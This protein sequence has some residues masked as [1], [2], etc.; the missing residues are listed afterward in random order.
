MI[1]EG[2]AANQ[3]ESSPNLNQAPKSQATEK[4]SFSPIVPEAFSGD[5]GQRTDPRNTEVFT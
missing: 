5:T 4:V 2:D 3:A 1:G